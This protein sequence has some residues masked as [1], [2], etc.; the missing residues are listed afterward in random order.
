[1]QNEVDVFM[2]IHRLNWAKWNKVVWRELFK[3]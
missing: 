3:N 2:F 1:M